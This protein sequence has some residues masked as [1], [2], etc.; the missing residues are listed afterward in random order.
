MVLG[1]YEHMIPMLV[2]ISLTAGTTDSLRVPCT[3][4]TYYNNNVYCAPFASASI[5]RYIRRDSLLP[6][7]F[8]DDRNYRIVDFQVAPFTV[9]LYN[10]L[11]IDKYYR[12]S[13]ERIPVYASRDIA[14]FTVTPW[15][16]LIIADRKQ[17]EIIFLD[18]NYDVK[19]RVLD[20][21]VADMCMSEETLYLLTNS[22][23]LVCDELC[24][25][26]MTVPLPAPCDR[27][28]CIHGMP[29]VYLTGTRKIR[30]F[31]TTWQE[32]ILSHTIQ[33]VTCSDSVVFI[34]GDDGFTLYHY[35]VSDFR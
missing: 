13:G 18:G 24:N 32:T 33:D 28:T 35:S 11:T 20:M 21:S 7:T 2:L 30:T 31:S 6:I 1:Y 27:V 16:E 8:T 23:L 5:Y 19:Y 22:A 12:A 17:R 26:T 25:T 9:Y 4:M 3:T 15:E 10:G 34:L 14:A 29:A